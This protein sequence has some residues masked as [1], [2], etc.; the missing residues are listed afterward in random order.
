MKLQEMLGIKYPFIQ[1]GMANIATGEFAAAVSEAGGLGLIGSGGMSVSELEENIDRAK[2]LTDKPFGVNLMLLHPDVDEMAELMIKKE[3]P[4]VT[5]GAGNPA[6]YIKDWK[7]SGMIVIPVIPNPTLGVRMERL[8]VDAVIA[9]GM[10][11]G[12]H[13]GHMTTLTLLPQTVKRLKIPVIAAGGIASGIQMLAC[14]VMGAIGFQ[15][16][17][18]FLATKECP[19]HQAYKDKVIKATDTNVTIIGMNTGIP[20]RLLRN[21]MSRQYTEKECLGWDKFQLEKFT[22][23]ALRRA[24]REGD[25]STGS[26]MAGL[27]VAQLNEE[28]TVAELMKDLYDDY[29]TEKERIANGY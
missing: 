24:V 23:G 8:G 7:A 17:T 4:I 11:A 6:K 12:G 19:I 1:G 29:L 26:L 16:G 2:A 14:E 28:K 5:T 25:V 21:E 22:L 27:T 20:I 10:E 15:I 13:I 18:A 9:E 3:I